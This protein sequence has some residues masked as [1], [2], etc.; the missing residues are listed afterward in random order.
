MSCEGDVDRCLGWAGDGQPD[1]VCSSD[2]DLGSA[3]GDDRISL[4]MPQCGAL[5]SGGM[6]ESLRGNRQIVD[7]DAV[8]AEREVQIAVRFEIRGEG[9]SRAVG[10]PGRNVGIPIT[11][12]EPSNC[13]RLQIDGVKVATEGAEPTG[14]VHL[15]SESV[16][17]DGSIR[18]GG[19]RA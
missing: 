8:G 18:I 1:Q 3:D 16:G 9:K 4:R 2:T 11:V 13:L 12:G 15:V 19:V 7:E 10:R 5:H 6:T 17:D 14:T